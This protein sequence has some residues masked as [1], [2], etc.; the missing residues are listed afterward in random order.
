MTGGPDDGTR[1][2]DDT[3]WAAWAVGLVEPLVDPYERVTTLEAM[4]AQASGD[5]LRAVTLLAG[6]LADVLDS[7][8][9]ND[10]WRHVDPDTFGTY[11]DGLDLVPTEA[12]EIREDIGLAALARPL[13]REGAV[14][15]HEAEHG[16]ENVAHAASVLDDPVPPL[17]RAIAWASWRRRA[18]VGEDSYPVLVLFSWLRRAALVAAGREIDDDQ[19]RDEM[20]ETARIVDDLA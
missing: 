15:V 2:W 4:R 8:P 16:W 11:R 13:G 17:T 1:S 18:Y 14:L 6:T 20:R 5:R 12:T 19:V 7:L 10:A 3:T 9:E